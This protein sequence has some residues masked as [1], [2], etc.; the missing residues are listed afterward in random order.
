LWEK[1]REE[2]KVLIEKIIGERAKGQVSFSESL[3]QRNGIFFAGSYRRYANL[4]D[5]ENGVQP[6]DVSVIYN[7]HGLQTRL[8]IADEQATCSGL[9][10]LELKKEGQNVQ[11]QAP[12]PTGPEMS[13]IM[14]GKLLTTL[15]SKKWT[16][17]TLKDKIPAECKSAVNC[18]EICPGTE[19][20]Y[21]DA[22][23]M[24]EVS[25]VTL[26]ICA[27]SFRTQVLYFQE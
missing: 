2:I 19:V 22:I 24:F 7:L 6:N 27:S 15:A 25:S 23:K 21:Q 14:V 11:L 1:K 5:F 20:G 18:D 26:T 3:W 13:L 12:N 8:K 4:A 16:L 10:Y 17:E 9:V